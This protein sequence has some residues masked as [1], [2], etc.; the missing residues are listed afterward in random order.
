MSALSIHEYDVLAS[1]QPWHWGPSPILLSSSSGALGCPIH[2]MQL[3]F[4]A[5]LSRNSCSPESN[6]CL[7]QQCPGLNSLSCFAHVSTVSNDSFQGMVAAALIP[8]AG[9]HVHGSFKGGSLLEGSSL[10]SKHDN[11]RR[12]M[13]SQM[14]MSCCT[15][16]LLCSSTARLAALP[17][18]GSTSCW[19][20]PH[21]LILT[22]C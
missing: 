3:P 6:R 10:C 16:S 11:F 15:T 1:N 20:L 5:T 8:L 18:W 17:F 9:H 14:S 19:T 22:M 12:L 13:R 21:Y 2:G 7:H 4:G